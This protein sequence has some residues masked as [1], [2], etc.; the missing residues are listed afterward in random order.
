M[1]VCFII[2]QNVATVNGG[3]RTQALFTIEE[4]KKQGINATLLNPWEPI[5]PKN[6]DIIH[7]F[8]AGP[9]TLGVTEAFRG[10]GK[11]LVISPIFF[12]TRSPFTIGASLLVEK[13]TKPFASGIRSDFSIKASMCEL[14][15]A[16]LP[17]TEAESELLVKGLKIDP[18][19]ITVVPNGV[20]QRFAEPSNEEF[21]NVYGIKNFV[22][23]AG[24]AGAPRKGLIYLLEAGKNLDAPLVIIG[25]LYEDEYGDRCK[26]IIQEHAHMYHIPTLH[27]SSPILRSAYAACRVFVLPSLFETPG[28]AAMEAA[29]GDSNI[30]ITEV[31]GTKEYFGEHAEYVKPK[32]VKSL[33][34]AIRTA[35]KKDKPTELKKRILDNYTWEIVAT[36]T[37]EV[38]ERILK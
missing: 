14:A 26:H 7:V 5:Q 15:D 31:G 13:L 4:L 16:I 8:R 20:E 11:K 6:I 12:S 9:D 1:N 17:N 30:V 21:L 37:R 27:H 19:K 18:N 2:P 29:L 32:D 23:F 25:D 33:E 10:L 35:L 34:A 3:V 28:I 38:Y 22:L 24:Q 36:K